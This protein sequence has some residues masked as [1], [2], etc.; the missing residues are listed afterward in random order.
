MA[1]NKKTSAWSLLLTKKGKG[2]RIPILIHN[3]KT[4]LQ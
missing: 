3:S 2:L 1:I 4:I